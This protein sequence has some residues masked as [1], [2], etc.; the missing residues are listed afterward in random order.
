[1]TFL[2]KIAFG[3]VIFFY[4]FNF[5]IPAFGVPSVFFVLLI[6]FSLNLLNR[7][8]R[9]HTLLLLIEIRYILFLI[10]FLGFYTALLSLWWGPGEF[11]FVGICIKFFL[12]LLIALTIGF[13][14]KNTLSDHGI[15]EFREGM[16]IFLDY[17]YWV[18][19]VQALF[20]VASFISPDFRVFLDGFIVNRGNIDIEHPFRFRGLHDSG[21][22]NLSVVLGISVVYGFFSSFI[23][24][25]GSISVRFTAFLLIFLSIT[26]VARTGLMVFALGL[27]LILVRWPIKTFWSSIVVLGC[28]VLIIYP[29]SEIFFPAEVGNFNRTVFN[30]AFE[31]LVNY[32]DSGKV[33]SKS[34]DDLKTMLFIPDTFN[35]FFG[36][37]S[38][39]S[40]N[41]GVETS[42]SGYL[43]TLL[44]GGVVGFAIVYGFIIYV[45]T[46]LIHVLRDFHDISFFVVFVILTM[47]ITE[48]KGPVFYQNDSSRY[49]LLLIGAILAYR[50][51]DGKPYIRLR[52]PL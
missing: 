18:C 16:L 24:R 21:G 32:Q 31:L 22:F 17:L 46:R 5:T 27:G 38:F 36:S 10:L 25:R 11:I 48:I 47:F 50:H 14:F 9:N 2:K 40:R 3:V 15:N 4:I 12:S 34:T 33:S 51:S 29:L 13:Y 37:G 41:A 39:G 30:Y 45:A 26:L 43:K 35:I 6:Y 20:I 44:A 19:A 49:L 1:M 52:Q 7:Q 23:L 42:D 28:S 8:V